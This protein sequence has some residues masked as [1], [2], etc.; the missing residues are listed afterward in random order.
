MSK[1]YELVLNDSTMINGG[2]KL[3]Q[4]KALK[5][6]GDVR[7]GDLGGYIEKEDNL[8]QEG[9]AWVSGNAH[10]TG[11]ARVSENSRVSGNARVSDNSQ[12]S[13]DA[14]VLEN[15][16]VTDNAQ[17]SGNARVSGN[18]WVSG[19]AR[20]RGSAWVSENYDPAGLRRID[21]DPRAHRRRQRDRADVAPLRR[22]GLRAHDLLD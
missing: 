16:W 19:Y 20:V 3:Y 9:D 13:G 1:K 11:D 21:V 18:A 2:V 12:V 7:K 15:A 6:F 22:R 4:I 14:R 8:S 10:V 5:D 17:V